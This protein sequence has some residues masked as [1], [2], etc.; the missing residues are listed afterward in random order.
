MSYELAR[1][2]KERR[3]V[4]ELEI[5]HRIEDLRVYQEFITWANHSQHGVHSPAISITSHADTPHIPD[6]LDSWLH[7]E[8]KEVGK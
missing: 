6:S 7:E 4:F 2:Q 3:A 8:T 5:Q 1:Q